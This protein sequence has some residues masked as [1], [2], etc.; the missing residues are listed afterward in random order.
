MKERTSEP[1]RKLIMLNGGKVTGDWSQDLETALA[2][3]MS[4]K[5]RKMRG[6]IL[7]SKKTRKRRKKK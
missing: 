2:V 3:L 7:A 5:H 1:M 4:E 6:K